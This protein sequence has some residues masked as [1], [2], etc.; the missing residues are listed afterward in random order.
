METVCITTDAIELTGKVL[1]YPLS[2]G[3]DTIYFLVKYVEA[4]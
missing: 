2:S 4:L 1:L 3:I